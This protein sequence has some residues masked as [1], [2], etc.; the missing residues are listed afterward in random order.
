MLNQIAV[1]ILALAQHDFHLFAG[2][3]LLGRADKCPNVARRIFR[4]KSNRPY[5]LHRPAGADDAEFLIEAI[6]TLQLIKFRKHSLPVLRMYQFTVRGWIGIER[7]E[8]SG[9][10]SVTTSIKCVAPQAAMKVP[11]QT[12][13]QSNGRS[14]FFFT[15]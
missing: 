10:H 7:I 4:G 2:G 9:S 14:R 3:N 8:Y 11:K 5:P 15:R 6:R 1:A 13:I 12:N